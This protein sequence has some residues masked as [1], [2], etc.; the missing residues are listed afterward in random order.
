VQSEIASRRAFLKALGLGAAS[1]AACERLPVRQAMP[2][3]VPPEEITP[4][5]PTFYRSTCQSCTAS[6]GTVVKVVAGRPVKIEGNRE[7]PS[8]RGGLCAIG[9]ASLRSLY[10]PSRLTAP[11]LEGKPTTWSTLDRHVRDRLSSGLVVRVLSKTIVSPTGRAAIDSFLEGHDGRWVEHD[12]DPDKPSALLEAYEILTGR[13]LQPAYRFE[14]AD[15]VVSLAADPFGTGAEP[16][17]HTAA[18]SERRRASA[19]RGAARHVQ[20][21]GGYSLT[22]AHADERWP[23][24]LGERREITLDILGR[25]AEAVAATGESDEARSIADYL[26]RRPSERSSRLASELLEHRGHSLVL[27]G[28]NDRDSQ[29]AV[30]WTN[31]LLGNEES[32]LDLERPSL[33]SKGLDRELEQLVHELENGRVGALFLHDID[34]LRAFPELTDAIR[35]LPLSVAIGCR[36]S[37]TTEACQ[38]VAASHHELESWQDLEPRARAT[39]LAQPSVRPLFAT[40]HGF[41]NFLYWSGARETDWRRHLQAAWSHRGEWSERVRTAG[42]FEL[43]EAQTVEHAPYVPPL[44]TFGALPRSEDGLEIEL[45]S[46]IG[47]RTGGHENN[48][49]L[50]ELPDPLTRTAWVPTVRIAPQTARARNIADGDIVEVSTARGSV[51]IP[52]L[53]MPGQH[54][55]VIGVPLGYGDVPHHD[56]M[57]LASLESGRLRFTAPTAEVKR[58]G[59]REALPLVQV[60]SDT[61]GRPIVHQLSSYDEEV[62]RP[63]FPDASLWPER[64]RKSPHWGMVIDLDACTG[65]SACIVACQSENNVAVVGADEVVLQREM[66]WIRIDR[67]FVGP[68][69]SPDVVFQP[70]ICQQC[71]NAP[72]ETVCPVAATVHS[73]DGL[74]QQVYNRCVGTRYCA[75]NCPYKVR[76]FNWFDLEPTDP[77]ERLVLNPDVVVRSRGVME[78]CTFC[79]QRIQGARI[80]ARRDGRDAFTVETACQQSCPAQ[81][82]TFGDVV[83]DGSDVARLEST[84]RSFRVLEELGV[85]PS[86]SYLARV[87]NREQEG[88]THGDE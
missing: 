16:V 40:R 43:E 11:A 2:Y 26:E 61:L 35:A 45:I 67:Y 14:R 10:D 84:P 58:T 72:C 4:G 60:H 27:S 19:T 25:V 9:Q 59:G 49:W 76:R 38:A 70:M 37:K 18:W 28:D 33:S 75:N 77:V 20:I 81:A 53:L 79:V 62:H 71:D 36:A 50:R 69:D 12:I 8:S 34:I 13:S 66:H 21:E 44:P 22:G 80:E 29:L 68:E 17:A 32:T 39:S 73:E 82:I 85:E 41:E 54:P 46:E 7:H 86:V 23:A 78:K 57:P 6:C 87:R 52:A 31:R 83:A 24:S 65:C 47:T 55:G 15:L 42:P 30:A 5:V 88:N 63:H 56:A 51:S 74:N 3:L 48:P 64:E 1:L